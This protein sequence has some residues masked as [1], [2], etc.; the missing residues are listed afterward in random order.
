MGKTISEKG[1]PPFS[2][3][4]SLIE[5]FTEYGIISINAE[6]IN[7]SFTGAI[8]IQI[9]PKEYLDQMGFT[10][11]P[12]IPLNLISSL[13]ECKSQSSLQEKGTVE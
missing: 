8:N 10:F 7:T 4:K 11:F 13:R 1:C 6:R 3:L 5:D 12:K 2:E 9:A